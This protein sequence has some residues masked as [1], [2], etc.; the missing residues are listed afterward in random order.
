MPNDYFAVRLKQLR[1]KAKLSQGELGQALGVS[2]GAISYYENQ[3]RIPNI[4]FLQDVSGYF[5]VSVEY[6]LGYSNSYQQRTSIPFYMKQISD[7]AFANL[8]KILDDDDDIELFNN[9]FS[10]SR[11]VTF[12]YYF[13]QLVQAVSIQRKMKIESSSD[14]PISDNHTFDEDYMIFILTNY[15]VDLLRETATEQALQNI[16]V[17][18]YQDT[19]DTKVKKNKAKLELLQ[20]EIDEKTSRT[21]AELMKQNAKRLE[22]LQRIHDEK[23]LED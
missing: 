18:E 13:H 21:Y 20:K 1:E 10:N 4:D 17:T 9:L 6:L 8:E 16:D 2:R 15:L 19:L 11:I 12:F 5:N 3:E 14:I 7:A 22:V 23:N